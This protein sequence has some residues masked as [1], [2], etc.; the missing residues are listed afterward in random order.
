MRSHCAR[1]LESMTSKRSRSLKFAVLACLLASSQ[2]LAP[3]FAQDKAPDT[4]SFSLG[5]GL[6]LMYGTAYEY[7]YDS[8]N[9]NT[10][11]EL[12]WDL[13]PLV[14]IAADAKAKYGKGELNLSFA[15]GLPLKSGIMTDSDWMNEGT[16]YPNVKTNYSES[17][18][19][20]EHMADLCAALSYAFTLS[21]AFDLKPSIGFRYMNV[22]WSAKGGWLQYADESGSP[23][24]SSYT[25]GPIVP[26]SGKLS[27]YEQGYSGFVVGLTAEWRISPQLA[28]A[29]GA[30]ASPFITATAIDEHL[31]RDLTFTD[32]MYDGYLVEPNLAIDWSPNKHL[33]L[34]MNCRYTLISGLKGTETVKAGPNVDP[35]EGIL[36]GQSVI[37]L[38][39]AGAALK[40]FGLRV[41]ADYHFW[42]KDSVGVL[43]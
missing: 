21:N 37:F 10:M 16:G 7:V 5:S 31:L 26:M 33:E 18:A 35:S 39:A 29:F 9:G 23:P 36:P 13:K 40:A 30:Q 2:I 12:D 43:H 42:P 4:W 28:L 6:G 15:L 27:T 32:K 38:N 17:D 11:S 24:Y 34:Q 22:K 1:M 3:G 20:V 41:V 19:I 8:S 14:S 25:T